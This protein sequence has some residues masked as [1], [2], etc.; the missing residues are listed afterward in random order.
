M[1][2]N[3]NAR[4]I[5]VQAALKA[6]KGQYNKFGGYKYRSC[7]DI[8]EAVKPLLADQGLT[9]TLTDEVLDIGGWHYVQATATVSNGSDSV[10]CRAYA[11]ES[12]TKKGMDASQITGTASSYARKYA[13]NGLFLIDD[14]KDADATQVEPERQPRPNEQG[15][16]TT[17]QARHRTMDELNRRMA[18]VA[19]AAGMDVA[20]LD[21][22]CRAAGCK[23]VD[24]A[25]EWIDTALQQ[26]RIKPT[27]Q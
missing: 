10:S 16:A 5:A 7:E 13:L 4:L 12:E 23:T 8:L 1:D 11:R 17:P 20:T 3:L 14:T 24:Q 27:K 18:E 21:G 2:N 19:V 15:N 26:G 9:L 6:P 22:M 25:Y